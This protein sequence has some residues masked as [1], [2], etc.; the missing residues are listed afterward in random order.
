[1]KRKLCQNDNSKPVYMGKKSGVYLSIACKERPTSKKYC[2]Y[3]KYSLPL[4]RH[5]FRRC[6]FVK[7]YTSL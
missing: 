4:K 2:I 6:N 1:M 3:N 5:R 7:V